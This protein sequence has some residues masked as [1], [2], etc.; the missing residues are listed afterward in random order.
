M[1]CKLGNGQPARGM[2]WPAKPKREGVWG[3]GIDT[4]CLGHLGIQPTVI[5]VLSGY[6]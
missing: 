3:G 4:D 1:T 2:T 5:Q 6:N